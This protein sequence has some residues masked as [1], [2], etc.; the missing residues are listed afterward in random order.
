MLYYYARPNQMDGH[1]F[2]DDVAI[3]K[4][5]TKKGALQKFRR[6]YD[7]GDEEAKKYVHKVGY[8]KLFGVSVLTDY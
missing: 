4:A 7:I 1:R 6:L 8:N 2:T 3:C 5:F